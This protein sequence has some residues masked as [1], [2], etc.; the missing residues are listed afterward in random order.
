M[1]KYSR[2][3]SALA[4]AFVIF[5]RSFHIRA[6]NSVPVSLS[7]S[8]E[9]AILIES[10][11]GDVI[12]ELNA[13]ERLPMASTTKIMTALVVIETCGL[14]EVVSVPDEAVGIEGSSLYLKTGEIL[15]CASCSMGCC[16]KAQMTRRQR[17][18]FIQQ[19]R[20]KRSLLS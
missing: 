15:Q 17:W 6:N 10:S 5:S 1:S 3:F 13:D 4:A 14:D 2:L 19:A 20:L 11:S 8:A 12:Y 7:T 18:R 9:A 16:F